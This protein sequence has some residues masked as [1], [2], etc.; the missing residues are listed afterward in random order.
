MNILFLILFALGCLQ[1]EDIS[2][3]SFVPDTVKQDGY[4]SAQSVLQ[5]FILIQRELAQDRMVNL[6]KYTDILSKNLEELVIADDG[7]KNVSAHGIRYTKE[8]GEAKDLTHA[9]KAYQELSRTVVTLMTLYPNLQDG[10]YI[11]SCPMVDGYSKWVQEEETMA[12]PYMGTMMLQCGTQASFA[13]EAPD[14]FGELQGHYTCSMHPSVKQDDPGQ[15][16]LCNMDLT[17]IDANEARSGVVRVDGLR[18]QKLGIR[19]VEI[20]EKTRQKKETLYAET[21]IDSDK[22]SVVS[23]RFSAWISKLFTTQ[24]GACV[25]KGEPLMEVFSP[26]VYAAQKEYLIQKNSVA[27]QKLLLLG[28]SNY[29]VDSLR[30]AQERVTISAPRSGCVQL[31]HAKEGEHIPTGRSILEIVPRIPLLEMRVFQDQ[32]STLQLGDRIQVGDEGNA[33]VEFID[34]FTTENGRTKRIQARFEE[35]PKDALIGLRKPVSWLR[36]EKGLFV[37]VDS[38]IF[39][40]E[41]RIVFLDEGEDRLRPKEIQIGDRFGDWY[42][43]KSGLSVGDRIAETGVF[44]LASESRLRS[45]SYFWSGDDE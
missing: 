16:P 15:C 12:N 10:K 38:V 41:R 37:P 45:S 13:I 9:R 29:W 25:K 14:D 4:K 35:P 39:T 40:G 20:T 44:L 8:L 36:E 31:V 33:I 7:L 3:P 26:D 6:K 23:L 19:I 32:A 11:Y 27:K 24:K 43:V 22:V 42:L 30:S 5:Q 28:F 18:R 17:Y 34:P 21:T 2:T 1:Q